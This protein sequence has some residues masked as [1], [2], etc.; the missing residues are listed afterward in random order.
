MIQPFT[1]VFEV[2]RYNT[3]ALLWPVAVLAVGV[4]FAIFRRPKRDSTVVDKAMF[5]LVLPVWL[6]IGI[7]VLL[8]TLG[9]GQKF[10]EALRTG[11]CSVVQ[12]VVT[13]LH[14]QPYS[15][16]SDG[17]II[18]VGGKRFDCDYF[19]YGVGYKQTISHGGCLTNGVVARLYYLGDTILKVE[20]QQ[21][22]KSLQATAA[23]P[24]SCD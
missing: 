4:L 6:L 21:P 17:D 16:H 14:Q 22:N 13:V 11:H 24:S 7:V 20:I 15:G 10:T 12:G 19:R 3:S 5:F 1:T 23:A 18:E 9:D 8:S 2:S